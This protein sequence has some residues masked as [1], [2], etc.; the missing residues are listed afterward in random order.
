MLKNKSSVHIISTDGTSDKNLMVPTVLL[1]HWKKIFISTLS[2]IFILCGSI[3]YFATSKK[4]QDVTNKYEATLDQVRAMN[5]QLSSDQN[6]SA[7]D[8]YHVKQSF[9]KIDSTLERINA[10]MKKRGLKTIALQ[11]AGGPVELD[12]ENIELLSEFYADALKEL[13]RKLT[14]IPIG[15]PHPGKITS[16]FGYR[17]NPFTN[18]GREMHS[19]IDL[20]GRTGDPVKVTARGKVIFAGYEGAYGNVV[21][22][23]HPNGFQTRYAHLSKTKVRKGQNI[24]VGAV[25]GLLGNTGRSTGSHLH[26][27]ILQN[28]K[29]L[30]P[31]KYFNF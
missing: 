12:E 18:R 22:V 31:E 17:R 5:R 21:K 13:D 29:K 9:N 11:N 1:K 26:Y 27:E 15:V 7:R 14:G 23:D 30:N 16:R 2:F 10:K 19:G 28:N 20:K 8:I 3:V 6:E 4:E 25:I 24:E